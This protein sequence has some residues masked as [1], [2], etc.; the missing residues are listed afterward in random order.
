MKRVAHVVACVA[1]LMTG[2]AM[3][4]CSD[5][6]GALVSGGPS[7][8]ETGPMAEVEPQANISPDEVY[9]G[10]VLDGVRSSDTWWANGEAGTE[11]VYFAWAHNDAGIAIHWVDGN[12]ADTAEQA[13][14]EITEDGHLLSAK[15]AEPEADFVFY[16]DLTCY[17]NVTQTWY[18]RGDAEMLNAEV[19]NKVYATGVWQITLADDGTFTDV[20]GDTT[21]TGTWAFNS[22]TTVKLT[23]DDPTYYPQVVDVITED[24]NLA[25]LS[26]SSTWLRLQGDAVPKAQTQDAQASSDDANGEGAEGLGDAESAEGAEQIDGSATGES[27]VQTGEEGQV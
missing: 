20:Y 18:M 5:G 13:S 24:G 27:V 2:F 10:N 1:V 9:F 8:S 19:S 23:Y 22:S 17:D 26:A 7:G 12:N 21:Q 11:G 14:V 25:A 6:M 16:D 3:A 15:D 4:G